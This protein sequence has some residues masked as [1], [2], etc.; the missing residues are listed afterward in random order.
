MKRLAYDLHVHS[1]LSPC[2]AD[3][4][5]PAAIAGMAALA[6]LGLVALTDHNACGNCP[7]FFAACE[8]YGVV[9]VAGMELTTAEDVHLV[10]L[11]PSLDAAAAFC[12]EV[13]KRRVRIPNRPEIFGFQRAVNEDD[14]LLYEEP[15][16]LINATTLS[17]EEGAALTERFGGAAYPAHIDRSANGILA[18]LGA[19]PETPDFR[20]VELHGGGGGQEMPVR[21]RELEGRRIVT[22]SDAHDLLSLSEPVNTLELPIPE[23][24]GDQAVRDALIRYLRGNA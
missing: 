20:T 3:D 13:G 1:C 18:V 22:S 7:A 4:A 8:F 10:C 9:P 12:E 23:T 5:T 14:E 21:H 17:I 24:A 11:F 15:D 19:L 16:L 2:A 6:G